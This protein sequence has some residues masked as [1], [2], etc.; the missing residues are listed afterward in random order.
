M[1]PEELETF[2][3]MV[4]TLE[5]SSVLIL[6]DEDRGYVRGVKLLLDMGEVIT[7][8][9]V[10]RVASIYQELTKLQLSFGE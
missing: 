2:E 7:P 3:S 9:I 5:E 6:N 10:G 8:E 1:T 4:N